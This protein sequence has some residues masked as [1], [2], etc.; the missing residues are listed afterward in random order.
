[1]ALIDLGLPGLPV[2]LVDPDYQESLVFL[3]VLGHLCHLLV[4]VVQFLQLFQ[5][6][7]KVQMDQCLLAVPLAPESLSDR[8]CLDYL[9]NQLA[10]SDQ[11]AQKDQVA[12][13]HLDFR[14]NLQVPEDRPVQDHHL[15]HL[16]LEN[17]YRQRVLKAQ[18]VLVDQLIQAAQNSLCHQRI[19]RHQQGQE[20]QS[21]LMNQ[22]VLSDP[23]NLYR[24]DFLQFQLDLCRLLDQ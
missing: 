15:D 6:C 7:Q 18:V 14:E 20:V 11:L 23:V 5:S 4:Q 22:W 12:Q 3:Q 1:M 9:E 21:G 8:K 17:L 10:L 13:F 2:L 19:Q 24:L 16:D